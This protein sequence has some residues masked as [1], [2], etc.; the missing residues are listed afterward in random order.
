MFAIEG[1]SADLIGAVTIQQLFDVRF[2]Q[3]FHHNSSLFVDASTPIFSNRQ[4]PAE[5]DAARR[6]AMNKAEEERADDSVGGVQQPLELSVKDLVEQQKSRTGT[7]QS[8]LLYE[9][10]IR[11]QFFSYSDSY[12][13]KFSSKFKVV[14]YE[15][16]TLGTKFYCHYFY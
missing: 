5:T 11:K 10:L 2:Q 9:E 16:I 12:L 13:I 3:L 15:N 4:A 14:K 6:R 7:P 8:H 1:T